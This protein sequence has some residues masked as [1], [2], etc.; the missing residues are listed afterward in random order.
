MDNQINWKN[1]YNIVHKKSK[2]IGGWILSSFFSR[3]KQV[4][5]VL[6]TTLVRPIVEYGCVVTCPHLKKDIVLL[7]QVQR[8][9]TAKIDGFRNLNYWERITKLG[10]SSLQRRR[11]IL[12][13]LHI[14][15]IKNGVYPNSISLQFKLHARSNALKAVLQPLPRVKGSL[16]RKY[17]ESFIIRAC[18]LWNILPPG[19]THVVIFRSFK[20]QIQNF[21]KGIRDEPPLPG[22]P[23]KNN[24]SLLEQCLKLR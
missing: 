22:Y 16:L 4:M 18:K 11:E 6:F 23:V 24:N 19:L 3:D 20:T 10:I 17:E 12:M 21:C 1:H 2:Q 7:E 15:K 9:F 14:W 13:I 5:L 8:S